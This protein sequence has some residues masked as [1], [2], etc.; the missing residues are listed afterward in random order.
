MNN[1][2]FSIIEKVLANAIQFNQLLQIVPY[3]LYHSFY[4]NF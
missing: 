2:I 4:G 3:W 1:S